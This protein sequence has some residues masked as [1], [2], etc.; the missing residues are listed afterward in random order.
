MSREPKSGQRKLSTR[1]GTTRATSTRAVLGLHAP[2][3]PVFARVC[4]VPGLAGRRRFAIGRSA[5]AIA[6]LLDPGDATFR[7]S[8]R[9]SSN[10]PSP[11]FRGAFRRHAIEW[12]LAFLLIPHVAER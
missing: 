8:S 12:G 1:R 10:L 7:K 4:C 11:H 5:A 2:H 9:E 3:H 6:L